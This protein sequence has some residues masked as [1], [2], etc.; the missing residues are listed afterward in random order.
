M[1]EFPIWAI[2]VLSILAAPTAGLAMAVLID[3]ILDAIDRRR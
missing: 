3:V 2:V 1:I